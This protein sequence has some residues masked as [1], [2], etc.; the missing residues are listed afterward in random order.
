[1]CRWSAIAAHLPGRTDNEIKNHWHTA[2]KKRFQHK[3]DTTSRGTGKAEVTKSKD[4]SSPVEE[5]R[6]LLEIGSE[7]SGGP[8]SPQPSSSGLSCKTTDSAA[9]ATNHENW[10]LEDNDF[11]FQDAYI[12]P[13]SSDFWTEPYLTDISYVPPSEATMQLLCE[14]E[15]FIA[16]NDVELWSHNNLDQEYGGLFY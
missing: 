15:Y 11:A 9:T 12:E 7:N 8:L 3:S 5:E 10:V 6:Q 4:H 1:M 13:V 14:H 2:L 16:M